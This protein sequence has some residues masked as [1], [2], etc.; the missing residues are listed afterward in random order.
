VNGQPAFNPQLTRDE[1]VRLANRYEAFEDAEAEAAGAAVNGGDFSPVHLRTI[2]RWKTRDR[3]RSRLT[4]NSDL[5][6]RDALN[7]ATR[8]KAP[9]SAVAVLMG[10][11]GVNV[12]V[13]S[14]IMTVIRPDT[15]TILDF[16]VLEALGNPTLDRSLPFYL[17]YLD[18]CIGLAKEWEMPLRH[19]DRA[20]WQWSKERSMQQDETAVTQALALAK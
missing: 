2:F 13:A 1:A 6:V 8:A 18:Y 3:G 5:E 12:P 19:L 15:Y 10:L 17:A 16:R 7:L 11:H 20:L 4:R 9:R 14:A